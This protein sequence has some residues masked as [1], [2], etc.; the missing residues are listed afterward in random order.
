MK[1]N[2]FSRT[3]VALL[4]LISASSLFA[5]IEDAPVGVAVKIW[6]RGTGYFDEGDNAGVSLSGT[7]LPSSP[8]AGDAYASASNSTDSYGNSVVTTLGAPGF[9]RVE[10]FKA[11]TLAA[12]GWNLYDG[13]I[14]IVAPPGYR[15]VMDQMIRSRETFD[16]SATVV[17]Q[18]QSLGA[19]HPGLAGMASSISAMQIDWH[20]SL[21]SLRN[22]G[23]AGDLT[24]IDTGMGSNWATI[25]TPAALF[26][27][28]NSDEISVYRPSNVIRQII[29]NQVVVDVVTLNSASY[30][31]RCYHPSQMTGS[32]N[33]RT[34]TGQPYLTYRIEEWV[35]GPASL[36]ITK[37]VRDVVD[38][39]TTNLPV[40]RAEVL[41]LGRTGSWP[42][43]EWAK[44][45]WAIDNYAV[46]TANV[47]SYESGDTRVE[48]IGAAGINSTRTYTVPTYG[49]VSTIGEVLSSETVGTSTGLTTSFDYYTNP[50]QFGS[51]GYLKSATT[52]GGGWVAYDYYDA[53]LSSG[54]RG[55]RVKR[56]YKPFLNA[57][58]TV[59]L[60]ASQGEVT[61]YEY[62]NDV[63]GTP[64]R[65]S[66]VQTSVNNVLTAKSITSY[67]DSYTSA[68]GYSIAQSTR[69]EYSDASHSLQTLVRYY[70]DD[71][72]DAFIRGQTHSIASPDGV[73]QSFAYQRGT[74]NGTSFT[75]GS[76]YIGTGTASRVSVVTGTTSSSGN[77]S[78]PAIDSYQLDT[79]Y[80]VAGKSTKDVTIRESRALVARTESHVW[81]GSAW[82]LVTFTNYTYDFAGR[83]TSRTASNGAT[84]TA[85]YAGGLKTTETDEAGVVMNYTYDSAGRVLVATR[86]G[87]GAIG[88]LA[89]HFTYDSANHVTEQQVGWGQSEKII[90]SR[91][92]DNAGRVSTETPSGGLGAT[93]HSYD[94]A[95]RTHTITRPGSAGTIVETVNLDGSLASTTGTSTVPSYNTYGLETDGR[96]WRQVNSGTSSSPRWQKSW[97]DWLGRN[98]K[99]E[100]PSFTGLANV[101]SENFYDSVGHLYKSTSNAFT[102]T[103]TLYQYNSLGQVYRSGLD[104]DNNGTLNLASNDRI[105][106]SDS[107]LES[108][109]GA[110]WMR[111]DTKTY[112]TLG[113]S[114]YVVTSISR[115]RLTGHP[116]NRLSESQGIDAEG[117]LTT[118]TVDVN[119]S[120]HTSTATT[121][122]SGIPGSMVEHT[123]NGFSIDVTG[124]DGLTGSTAYDALLRKSSATDSRGNTTTLTYRSGTSLPATVT[125][126]SGAVSA[127]TY[128]SLGRVSWQ[129]DARN[130]YTRYEY[131]TRDQ[132]IHTWGDGTMPVSYGYDSTYG[133]RLT[134]ST[135]RGGSGWSTDTGDH[136]NSANPWP[137]STVGTADT[138]T[139]TYDSPTG[140]LWKKTDA[141]T[142]EHPSGMTVTSTYNIRGQ[143]ATRTLARGTVTTYGYDAKTGEL[144]TQ[145]Y[146]DSTP[147]VAYTYGRTGQ[148]E[149]ITDFTG[150]R[151]LIYDATKPWRLTA[152]A[153]SAFYGSRVTT[154]LY[155]ETGTIGRVH[156]FQI[157]ATAG[158]NLDLEQ[159]F[160]FTTIGRFETVSSNRD[161]VAASS[162]RTFRY[163]YRSDSALLDHLAIDGG[164][165]FAVYR[166]YEAHRDLITSLD[167]KWSTTSR[168][169]YD[170]VSNELGQRTSTVQSGSA[171]ADYGDS[172]FHLFTYDARGEVTADVGYLGAT[173]ADQSKP[174]P[175]RKHE[176]AYDNAGNRTSSNRTG[177]SGLADTYTTNALNQY[178]SRS[179]NTIPVSGT[180]SP[181]TGGAGGTAVAVQGG[182]QPPVA[183]G[184]QGAY[185]NDELAV[186]NVLHPWRGPLT[187]FT[188]KRG[189]TDVFKVESRMAEIAAVLQNFAYDNDGNLTSDGLVDYAYDAENRLVRM[190]TSSNAQ[191]YNF[192]HKLLEF[193]YD[194]MGRRVQKRV[195]DVD[196][197]QEISCRRY[198]YDGWNL[199]AEYAAPGGTSIGALLRSYTW[200]LDIAR[201]LSNAGG[202]GALLQIADHPS[203][204]TYLPTYDGNGNIVSLLNADNESGATAGAVAAVYEYGPVG[205]P[206]RA[207]TNDPTIADNPFRFST[208]FTDLETGLVYYG[209]RYYDPHNGRF[210]NKD[211]IEEA[212]GLNLYGFCGNDGVNRW[213]YLGMLAKLGEPALTDA[214]CEPGLIAVNGIAVDPNNP[215]APTQT[216]AGST[217]EALINL[218][219]AGSAPTAV[220]LITTDI[221][222]FQQF[223]LTFGLSTSSGMLP[224]GDQM[225]PF[226][227]ADSKINDGGGSLTVG[228][229]ASAFL[230]GAGSGAVNFLLGVGDTLTGMSNVIMHP[231]DSAQNLVNAAGAFAGTLSTGQGRA[232]LVADLGTAANNLVNTTQGG[233]DIARSL[234]NVTGMILLGAAMSGGGGG[235]LQASTAPVRYGADFVGPLPFTRSVITDSAQ[236]QSKFKHA[237]DFGVTGNYTASN[238]ALFDQAIQAF[239]RDPAT[240]ALQGS[241]RGQ[242]AIFNVNPTTG[243][244][245]IS[246]SSGNFISG[247]KLN[248]QQLQNLLTLG[249][250]GGG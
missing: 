109:S 164:S 230:S 65:P 153:E 76:G 43:F 91:T 112:P 222:E 176:F 239:V 147:A 13:E 150:T 51:L 10:P 142:T 59:T 187:I 134:M 55:G 92:F 156:G 44:F 121:A 185:W 155:D 14:N 74:W 94:V 162:G 203:G 3:L 217:G 174:L 30:E 40:A 186:G 128:D 130:H 102:G 184:R 172:T 73:K 173:I 208:K 248:P 144:L 188:A 180:A 158:S 23:S 113:L 166:S 169:K 171:F 145:T 57:P 61:Y 41:K 119:R 35:L 165:A 149:T 214:D 105:T 27:E 196:A 238:G 52:P 54:F 198:L 243:L 22:G 232:D 11:Y 101:T 45:D 115:T 175:G 237:G 133:D 62:V 199:V 17:F 131:N 201:S 71:T 2:P 209:Q 195:V 167:S 117:N 160:G 116:T 192:P 93:T 7:F 140:L 50:S 219:V 177:V 67:N 9:V 1:K 211:P 246:D 240:E 120:A 34:F 79:V 32:S 85:A 206:L 90:T 228:Q 104:Y 234:G 66:L 4:A 226:V 216:A 233:D 106:E 242:P 70:R 200:G 36:K 95:N 215:T 108:Y 42:N 135:Y 138:T 183:A 181:D 77:T 126:A 88:E 249:K 84:Y 220:T 86:A 26:F 223:N 127:V 83:L 19:K 204:K 75:V 193:K 212:G 221:P 18:L 241:F 210:I 191:T 38:A 154:R 25:F 224:Q 60:S 72:S 163:A 197:S 78:C 189:T 64:S 143:T 15:V 139:W 80:L 161:G 207:Q 218:T 194:Y 152:E 46:S 68:N 111:T 107:Y 250:L 245:T 118:Q 63:F 190:E 235:A 125:D 21:G 114:T 29:A 89:T 81:S 231:F 24:L 98:I 136:G 100:S 28:T 49:G 37:E 148:V 213:D 205:E 20:V 182:S 151:D 31:I 47:Q 178:V 157:G 33:P 69:T 146:S 87:S 97:T 247:W 53:D 96:R 132:V 5:Q 170:Y 202:V 8:G 227:V 99:T 229:A 6:A 141:P 110:W 82:Q 39:V 58:A 56:H 236:L 16:G 137:T 124:V 168:T 159:T 123:L 179:N 225:A 129:R 122:R 48:Q 103:A 12:S 244:T